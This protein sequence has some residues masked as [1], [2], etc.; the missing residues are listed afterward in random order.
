V[1]QCVEFYYTYKNQARVG[2]NGTFTYGPSDP[3]ESLP[4]VKVVT[5]VR[6]CHCL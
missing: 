3:E 2:R 1:A 5:A 4:V 6:H